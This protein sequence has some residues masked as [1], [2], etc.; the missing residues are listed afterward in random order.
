MYIPGHKVREYVAFVYTTQVR[1]NSNSRFRGIRVKLFI[2]E[3]TDS[4]L[5]LKAMLSKAQGDQEK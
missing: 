3:K 1:C 2:S 4:Q 5:A